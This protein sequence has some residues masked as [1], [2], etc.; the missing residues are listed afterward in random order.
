MRSAQIRILLLLAIS[1]QRQNLLTSVGHFLLSKINLITTHLLNI[2]NVFV[3]YEVK[4][5]YRCNT[6]MWVVSHEISFEPDH[7]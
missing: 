2:Q 1:L 4:A 5:D 3:A 7:S 6:H